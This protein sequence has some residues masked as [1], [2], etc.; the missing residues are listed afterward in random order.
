MAGHKAAEEIL[1]S[2]QLHCFKT[3]LPEADRKADQLEAYIYCNLF[4][5][6]KYLLNYLRGEV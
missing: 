2:F 4:H 1:D 3:V 6:F 5:A